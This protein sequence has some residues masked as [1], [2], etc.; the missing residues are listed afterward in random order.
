VSLEHAAIEK[1]G[2]AARFQLVLRPGYA[3]G[4]A[5]KCEF[6]RNCPGQHIAAAVMDLFGSFVPF[7]FC[8]IDEGLIVDD[9]GV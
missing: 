6:H 7:P 9:N 4:A 5:I 3:T 8:Y 1:N 2:C